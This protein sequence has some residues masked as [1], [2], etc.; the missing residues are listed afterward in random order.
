MGRGHGVVAALYFSLMGAE[1]MASATGSLW[2]S[3]LSERF[4]AEVV[5]KG[6]KNL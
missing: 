3:L 4:R 2:W 1:C 6:A 5:S